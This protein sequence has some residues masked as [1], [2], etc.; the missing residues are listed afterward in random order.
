MAPSP[1]TI[2]LRAGRWF[3]A[4]DDTASPP[5]VVLGPA[6]A[7]TTHAH[8]GET[9]TL[10]TAAGP[11]R[12]QV[13]GIDTGQLN[14]GGTAYFPLTVLQRLTGQTGT[15]NTLWLT[16]RDAS[17]PAVD[18][19]TAEV[20][21]RL[22]TA[23]YQVDADKLYVE[24][25]DNRAANDALFSPSYKSWAPRRDHH[26]HRPRQRPHHGRHRTNTRD[27]HPPLP[28]GPRAATSDVLPAAEGIVLATIG[29]A[30]GTPVGWLL[31]RA[32]LTFIRNTIEIEIP[33]AFPTTGPLVALAATIAVTVVV[34]RPSLRRATRISQAPPSATK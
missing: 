15:T 11:T 6:A 25:A 10:D 28:R 14:N 17:H 12:F 19:V 18:Q 8:V 31:S 27:R 9:I 32:L 4:A 13:V 3:N 21:D 5:A 34:I 16:T 26:A 7:R 22:D 29:W 23:G 33:P 24:K 2:R 1:C 20:Q 30:V